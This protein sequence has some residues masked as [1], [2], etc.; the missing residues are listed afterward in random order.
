[1]S[2]YAEEAAH[3]KYLKKEKERK[4]DKGENS[5]IQ[6]ILNKLDH[7]ETL[8]IRLTR[9]RPDTPLCGRKEILDDIEE[10]EEFVGYGVNKKR[11]KN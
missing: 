9:C 1:M 6:K 3:E 5:K 11:D 8:L 4:Y 2:K 7:I 10:E